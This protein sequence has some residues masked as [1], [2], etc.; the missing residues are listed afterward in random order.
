LECNCDWPMPPWELRAAEEEEEDYKTILG[1]NVG[2]F[3]SLAWS[4]INRRHV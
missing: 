2:Q 3:K 1:E 4:K